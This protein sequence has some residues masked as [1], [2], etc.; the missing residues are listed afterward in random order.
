MLVSNRDLARAQKRHEK[1]LRRK[2]K[3]YVPIFPLNYENARDSNRT[4]LKAPDDFRLMENRL[5]VIPY[6][7]DVIRHVDKRTYTLMDLSSIKR[8]DLPA[9]SLLIS[10]MMDERAQGDTLREFLNVRAPKKGTACA[11]IFEKAQF[12]ETVMQL[13]NAD[14][15]HFMSRLDTSQNLKYS[16]DILKLAETFFGGRS[17]IRS[18]NSILTEIF[19]NTNNHA[20]PTRD[21]NEDNATPWFISVLE[22]PEKGK[23]SFCVIDLG[24]GVHD[25]LQQR[26]MKMVSDGK[27]TRAHFATVF[28]SSQSMMLR[29]HIPLGI[30]SSTGIAGRGQGLKEIYIRAQEEPYT[31]FEML[32]NKAWVDMLNLGATVKDSVDN[33]EGTVHYWEM[34]LS[35]EHANN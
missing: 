32:T 7:N 35:D 16:A 18:L 4:L 34:E 27:L 29:K 15:T 33:F 2:G 20:D 30:N 28:S 19:S 26:G 8:V 6:F 1:K 24:V 17:R 9:I 21:E 25:S 13:G 11:S 31:R 22:D 5:E 14:H 10:L 3:K 12:R 23:L